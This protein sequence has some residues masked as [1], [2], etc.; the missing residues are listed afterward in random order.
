MDNIGPAAP[1]PVWKRKGDGKSFME[2]QLDWG[3]KGGKCWECWVVEPCCSLYCFGC[4][5]CCALCNISKMYSWSVGQDCAVVN[6]CVPYFFCG[7][8]MSCFM[9]YAIRSKAGISGGGPADGFVG[10]CLLAYL[11]AVV[12]SLSLCLLTC[13]PPPPPHFLPPLCHS[14]CGCTWCQEIRAVEIIGGGQA[15]WDFFAEPKPMIFLKEP[16]FPPFKM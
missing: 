1:V 11:Y 5:W 2:G 4:W 9:R 10:D 13:P 7:S 3:E 8:C 6:H 12:P 15:P 14:C 16:K